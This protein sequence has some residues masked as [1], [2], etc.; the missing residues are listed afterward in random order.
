MPSIASSFQNSNFDE[1]KRFAELYA[2][3]SKT[4]FCVAP[5]ATT[6]ILE[7]L[8]KHKAEWGEALCPCR[9]YEDKAT[10]VAANYWICPCVPM[11]E[12]HQCECMLFLP[13][14]SE[15]ASNYQELF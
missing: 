7:G 13:A 3:D 12:R 6:V 10:E 4:F 5:A 2:K 9:H 11:Q 8:A 14:E 15:F 1:M